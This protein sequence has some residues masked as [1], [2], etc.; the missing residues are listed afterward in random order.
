MAELGKI[1]F[2]L[3]CD[4]RKRGARC[5]ATG[6]RVGCFSPVASLGPDAALIWLEKDERLYTTGPRGSLA[7]SPRYSNSASA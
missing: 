5:E 7:H 4:G 6:V 3:A 2:F 1:D